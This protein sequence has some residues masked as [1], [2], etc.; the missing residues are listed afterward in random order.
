M[1]DTLQFIHIPKV[2]GESI[3]E[4]YIE[5]EW[6]RRGG[7]FFLSQN[8][9]QNCHGQCSFWHNHDNYIHKMSCKTFCVVRDPVDRIISSYKYGIPS[10]CGKDDSMKVY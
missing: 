2:A 8:K 6:G 10:K 4:T 3:E 9:Q 1:I 5:R 7:K